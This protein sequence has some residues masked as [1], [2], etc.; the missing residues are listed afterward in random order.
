ADGVN[1][2]VLNV[3]QCVITEAR[4]GYRQTRCQASDAGDPP[5]VGQAVRFP[6]ELG[7]GKFVVVADDKVVL[8]VERRR[9][10]LLA[11]VVGVY[12][13]LNAG[14]LIEGLSVR[15]TGQQRERTS[16]A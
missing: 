11:V 2:V 4:E 12:L 14:R 16:C 5:S 1:A 7:E 15:I 10:V 13:L 9:R 6:G 8:A 3:N